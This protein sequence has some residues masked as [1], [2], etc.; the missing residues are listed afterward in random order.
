ML[1]L[2]IPAS[3]N[4]TFVMTEDFSKKQRV[5]HAGP[6][7]ETR[8]EEQN[9]SD[10]DARSPLQDMSFSTHVFSLNA[11]ALMHLGE[12]DGMPES[13]QDVE[14]ARHV[15]D[16]LTMLQ[17]KTTGNLTDQEEKLLSTVLYDLQLK[18]V[19]KSS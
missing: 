9:S 18:C 15:I 3:P 16:T 17:Q 14:A 4:N 7:G 6:D 19:Q 13:E 1:M 12:M 2:L 10:Q 8:V 11:M 5:F